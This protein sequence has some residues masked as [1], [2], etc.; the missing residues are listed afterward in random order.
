VLLVFFFVVFFLAGQVVFGGFRGG[1]VVLN[2]GKAA[3][4]PEH[5]PPC[6]EY[7][8]RVAKWRGTQRD[9][10]VVGRC[11]GGHPRVGVAGWAGTEA[12]QVVRGERQVVRGGPTNGPPGRIVCGIWVAGG[13]EVWVGVG[14]WGVGL[15]DVGSET[16][17][18][19]KTAL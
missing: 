2:F 7:R 17:M 19:P 4:E 8:C 18:D 16:P 12:L 10:G 3:H 15:G 5:L 6:Y 11:G 9:S 1:L 13:G 14:Q